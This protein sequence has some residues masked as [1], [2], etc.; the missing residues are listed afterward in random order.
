[1]L[2]SPGAYRAYELRRHELHDR[3]AGERLVAE[4]RPAARRSAP[5]GRRHPV[6]AVKARCAHARAALSAVAATF[7][8]PAN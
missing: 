5:S 7:G 4:A 6:R 8:A 1:M 2:A 3:V